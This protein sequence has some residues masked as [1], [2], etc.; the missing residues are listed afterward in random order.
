MFCERHHLY[1]TCGAL[2]KMS[3]A[4]V[5]IYTGSVWLKKK[6]KRISHIH[7]H[8][9]THCCFFRQALLSGRLFWQPAAFRVKRAVIWVWHHYGEPRGKRPAGATKGPRTDT[10]TDRHTVQSCDSREGY[11]IQS[12]Q[13]PEIVFPE[14]ILALWSNRNSVCGLLPHKKTQWPAKIHSTHIP[15]WL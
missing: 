13:A 15:S 11:N 1:S 7:T 10:M 6:K 12:W 5:N 14:Q 4:V 9:H 2:I 3:G 8:T